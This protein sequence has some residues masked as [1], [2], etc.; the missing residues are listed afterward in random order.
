[1]QIADRIQ[2]ELRCLHGEITKIQ[3]AAMSLMLMSVVNPAEAERLAELVGSEMRKVVD[4][5][6]AAAGVL[7]GEIGK[8]KKPE[9]PQLK[10]SNE[11]GLN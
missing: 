9:P 4:S 11:Q 8:V 2:M 6:A 7:M 1:V 3:G 5:A 10:D